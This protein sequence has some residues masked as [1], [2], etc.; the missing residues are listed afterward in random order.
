M[1]DYYKCKI[2]SA[3]E[4]EGHR[5]AFCRCESRNIRVAKEQRKRG[6]DWFSN[7][8]SKKLDFDT[9]VTGFS[10]LCL[11]LSAT[12]CHFKHNDLN[13][14]IMCGFCSFICLICTIKNYKDING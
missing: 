8:K 12:L 1:D 14:T 9:C 7:K 13:S 3:E 11:L 2:C 10:C 5:R 4:H 6:E